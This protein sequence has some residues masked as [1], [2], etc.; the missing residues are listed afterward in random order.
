MKATKA[1]QKLGKRK[2]EIRFSHKKAQRAQRFNRETRETREKIFN[3]KDKGRNG[4][5]IELTTKNAKSAE[6]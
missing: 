3:A 4:W 1:K 2:A 5:E 6:F